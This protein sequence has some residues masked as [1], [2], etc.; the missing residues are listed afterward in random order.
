[1]D[2]LAASFEGTHIIGPGVPL[3]EALYPYWP[4]LILAF[5]CSLVAVPIARRLA[6]RF[7]I[8]DIPND[9]VK[10]HEKPTPYLG[11]VAVLVGFLAA[12]GLGS[13]LIG[14]H[15]GSD[16]HV[17]IV[18]AAA[19]GAALACLLGLID[20]IKDL[21]PKLKLL[22]QAI[23]SL[24]LVLAA[25]KPNL[26]PFF[27]R[28]SI[29]ISPQVHD[30]LAYAIVMLFVLGASNSLNLLGGLDGLC[31][32]VTAI[33]TIGFLF[34]AVHLATWGPAS[35]VDEA[36]IV[37]GLALVGATLGFLVFNRH[38]AK[39]FLG[40]AGSVMLG[41]VIATMMMLF[42]SRSPRWWFASML[43]FGLPI[44]DTG[45]AL[46]RRALNRRP[47][48][49]S[50][51]SHIYDQMI[52]RGLGLQKTVALNYILAAIYAL[53]GITI[54]VFL[55]TRYA[56][57][58]YLAIAVLSFGFLGWKGYFRMVGLR[59]AIRANPDQNSPAGM[60]QTS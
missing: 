30:A 16:G 13:W 5:L 59:G 24:C 27:E 4:V 51:R 43:I 34:L 21:K 58:P 22:G 60:D 46:I 32:G 37:I 45:T 44:L 36:I 17:S 50:D 39:I 25:I 10:T 35:Q 28:V 47:L 11:G 56:M 31:G 52:D 23:C 2:D 48:F 18:L 29:Q 54:A 42:A 57:V 9:T 20:D 33:I 41:F 8:L 40:D 26:Y 49:V 3:S 55:R 1:M 38:P 19:F 15:M 12:I 14:R 6:F 53:L 7:N